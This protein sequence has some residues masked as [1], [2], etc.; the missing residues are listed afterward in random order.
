MQISPYMGKRLEG[1]TLIELMIATVIVAI[2]ISLTLPMFK[3]SLLRSGRTEGRNV[4]LQVA[5]DQERFFSNNFSF[6][7]DAQP[8][9][10]P[11]QATRASSDGLWLVTVTTCAGGAIDN[12]YVA[13]ATAQ[14]G[15]MEDSCDTLTLSNTGLRGATG[16][17]V[18]ECWSR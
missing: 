7:T 11:T 12:C 15:Q 2:L 6:S 14:V 5:A 9:A 13:T 3:G 10:S 4:L 16:D 1:F 8:Y 18:E 17:T